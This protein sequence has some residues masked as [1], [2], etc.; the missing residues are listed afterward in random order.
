M[1][2][3]E[4]NGDLTL[5]MAK[6]KQKWAMLTDDDVLYI[7]G[8]GEELFSRIQQRTGETRETIERATVAAFSRFSGF[9]SASE[10]N[11]V[12]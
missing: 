9:S 12:G 5:A 8:K 11:V 2:A 7:D 1:N 4:I 3:F 6:L 10:W